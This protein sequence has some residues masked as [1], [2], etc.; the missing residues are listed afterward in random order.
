MNLALN[1]CLEVKI[2]E[3]EALQKIIEESKAE[4]EAK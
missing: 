3:A 2:A 4:E 1:A